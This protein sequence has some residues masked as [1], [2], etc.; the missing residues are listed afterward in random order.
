MDSLNQILGTSGGNRVSGLVSGIDVDS[1]VA[2]MML[3]DSQ[4]L[5]QMQQRLQILE[6]QRD[7]YRS[8][9]TLLSGLKTTTSSLQYDASFQSKQATSSNE[10]VVTA[11]AGGSAG[12][13]TYTFSN[14]TAATAAQNLSSASIGS[15]DPDKSLVDQGLAA[16]GSTVTFSLTTYD[17]DG[18]SKETDF[19][20]DADTTT[21]NQVMSKISS[22]GAGVTAIYDEAN[23][24][25]SL[26]RSE[27]G[28]SNDSG[29][30]IGL[31]G[32]FLTDTLHL[33]E[34]NETGGTG[35]Q[36]TVN[37]VTIESATN[38]I[39]LNG[40]TFTLNGNDTTGATTKVQVSNDTDAIYKKISDFVGQ[41]NDVVKQINTKVTEKRDRDYA[42]L[43]DAQKKEMSDTDISSWT[44]KAKAGMLFSDDILQ[45]ALTQ[46]RQGIS[47]KVG[48]STDPDTLDTLAEIGI[49]TGYMSTDGTLE[50][51]ETKLKA[52]L[53]KDPQAV[54]N[55]FTA[56]GSGSNEDGGIDSS[57]G[58][59]ER[60]TNTIDSTITKIE[61]KAGNE[62][63]AEK[64]YYIGQDISD[65]NERI[66]T[67]KDHLQDL[68]DRYYSQ[69]TA[70][71]EAIS[72][73][74]QQ[75]SYIQ[76][77]TG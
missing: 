23:G 45:S 56:N 34:T 70:M 62:Q 20:F 69:F 49:T 41:Y 39:T 42:P 6:W 14:V 26:T 75:A 32:T 67:F 11:S 63:M 9:N 15:I 59:M 27:E 16:A 22:S 18:N 12:N 21:L 50:I 1:V 77:F 5:F 47:E 61:Q 37:G 76:G 46:M 60:L 28:N 33:S 57:A 17:A 7:D 35:A 52:A 65:M 73:A 74:N 51:D 40:T 72:Q 10:G 4:P 43:T 19:E 13:G 31:N 68:E 48:D 44:D 38:T 25:V 58:V 54:V 3:A 71:E 8:M 53:N 2:K 24:K 55:L 64:N 36:A 66:N 30:E 29:A